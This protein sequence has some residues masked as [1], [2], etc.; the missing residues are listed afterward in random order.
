MLRAAI[1]ARVSSDPNEI[2]RSVDEQEAECRRI[3]DREGWSVVRTFVDNDRS[4]SR[5]ARKDR[6]QYR[7]LMEFLRRGEADVL[8]MWEGSRAQRD[9]RDF[10]RLR[11]LCAERGILY[12][13]SGRIFDLT[14][15][16]DRFSTGLDALLAERE[17]DQTRDRVLRAVRANAAA[18]RPHG[19]LLYGYGREY[20]GRGVYVR[21]IEVPEQAAIIREVARRVRAGGSCRSIALELNGRGVPAPRGGHWD[22]TQVKRLVTNPGYVAQRVHRGQIIGDADWP[23]ILDEQTFADCVRRLNDPRRKTVHDSSIRHLLTGA[24]RCGVCG[25]PVATLKN[26]EI[27]SYICPAKFCVSVK[28]TT[29]EQFV[30]D[31]VIARLSRR[32]AL[33]LLTPD[34]SGELEAARVELAELRDRLDGFYDQAAAG[35]ITPGGL[36]RIEAR[37]L[38]QIEAA[39]ARVVMRPVAPLL[40]DVAG[41]DAA[42]RWAVLTIGQRREIVATVADIRLDRTGRG[43]RTFDPARLGSSRWVGDTRTWGELWAS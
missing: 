16:D 31:V 18:G 6:P 43:R 28:T 13:Y 14:R 42:D 34:R 23:Q 27:R 36:A 37:L 11:D 7:A 33:S 12:S 29:V 21:T 38:A 1:Y 2:G 17:S 25:E 22:P 41:L 40:R 10:L 19:K 24:M 32:D 4:A 35:K 30:T 39:E 5:Y 3:A 8:V 20:D 26:R 15:T 9:L